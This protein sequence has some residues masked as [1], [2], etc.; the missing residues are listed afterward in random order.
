M[1][2]TT[3]KK[4]KSQLLLDCRQ[5]YRTL[6]LELFPYEL[7]TSLLQN[8]NKQKDVL[9]GTVS[10]V[11]IAVLSVCYNE[12]TE[13]S[14][15]EPTTTAYKAIQFTENIDKVLL[16][17]TFSGLHRL[18]S[19][20]TS[21]I[22]ISGLC[23]GVQE[24]NDIGDSSHLSQMMRF[25]RHVQSLCAEMNISY[26]KAGVHHG[27]VLSSIVGGSKARWGVWGTTLD[28]AKE[29]HTAA[30]PNTVMVS[31]EA[32]DILMKFGHRF[33]EEEEEVISTNQP[34]AVTVLTYDR[35]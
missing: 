25:L 3:R 34:L 6:V 29:V 17:V 32:G 30:K 26:M 24:T 21:H 27:S 15:N 28:I 12:D 13:D 23:D 14:D 22:F 16:D 2:F 18:V 19:S 5:K 7:A 10:T 11:G 31:Q 20:V 1:D 33:E 4:R 35:H 9:E 8:N